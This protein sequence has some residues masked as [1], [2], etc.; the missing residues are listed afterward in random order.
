MLQMLNMKPLARFSKMIGPHIDALFR[1]EIAELLQYLENGYFTNKIMSGIEKLE[2][3]WK[4][5]EIYLEHNSSFLDAKWLSQIGRVKF[6][7]EA[8]DE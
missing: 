1:M 7:L 4:K 8:E 2:W 5:E 6:D 3:T